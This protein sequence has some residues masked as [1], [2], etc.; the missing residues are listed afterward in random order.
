MSVAW[1]KTSQ[2]VRKI[3]KQ[4]VVSLDVDLSQNINT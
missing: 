4:C 2:R 1:K 3:H